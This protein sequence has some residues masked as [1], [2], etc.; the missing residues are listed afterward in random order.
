MKQRRF[1]GTRGRNERDRL[2]RPQAEIRAA[3]DLE[4]RS[5]L[6]ITP[7]HLLETNRGDVHEQLFI[8]QGFGRIEL[9]GTPGRIKRCKDG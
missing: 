9:S 7:L 4:R 2:P 5:R 3:Q 6:I 1:A 8:T